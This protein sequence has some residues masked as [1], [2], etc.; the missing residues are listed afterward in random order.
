[1]IFCPFL[2]ISSNILLT[3]S[4]EKAVNSSKLLD[5]QNVS[6]SSLKKK[7]LSLFREPKNSILPEVEDKNMC[8]NDG[9]GRFFQNNDL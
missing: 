7:S 1:M 5:A 3:W 9:T 2:K 6:H 4:R 8:Y